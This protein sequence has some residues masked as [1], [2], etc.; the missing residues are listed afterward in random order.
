MSQS[1][2]SFGF[3]TQRRAIIQKWLVKHIRGDLTGIIVTFTKQ[4]KLVWL[5]NELWRFWSRNH[6]WILRVLKIHW[7]QTWSVTS[8]WRSFCVKTNRNSKKKDFLRNPTLGYHLFPWSHV[9]QDTYW[10]RRTATNFLSF[11]VSYMFHVMHTPC[12]RLPLVLPNCY[13]SAKH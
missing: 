10:R 5:F 8:Y 11:W 12:S 3:V 1:W 9:S 7:Y 2:N 13:A 6:F 4:L